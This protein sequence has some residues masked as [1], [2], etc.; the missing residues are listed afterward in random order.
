MEVRLDCIGLISAG[1][2]AGLDGAGGDILLVVYQ[3]AGRT[4]SYYCSVRNYNNVLY[5][6]RMYSLSECHIR[7][8]DY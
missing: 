3:P 6:C 5:L 1:A 8:S 2:A 4:P 7:R